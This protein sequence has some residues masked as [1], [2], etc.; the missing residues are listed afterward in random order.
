L[1]GNPD[2]KKRKEDKMAGSDYAE[3]EWNRLDQADRIDVLSKIF[4][5]MDTT[6]KLKLSVV[7]FDDLP[8]KHPGTRKNV[9]GS[10]IL[11]STET[12]FSADEEE[13]VRNSSN[14]SIKENFFCGS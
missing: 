11:A 4:P 7:Q 10:L 5:D 14:E 12:G 2:V 1:R 3:R 8:G 6:S 13:R 9:R